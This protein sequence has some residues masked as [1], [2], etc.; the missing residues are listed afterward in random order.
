MSEDD[1]ND[2]IFKVDTV[3][4]P[5]GEEN[6][7]DAPTKVGPMAAAALRELMA[8]AEAKVPQRDDPHAAAPPS[9]PDP[10]PEPVGEAKELPKVYDEGSE[11]DEAALRSDYAKPPNVAPV[12]ERAPE[13]V[14]HKLVS[15]ASHAPL[16]PPN[17]ASGAPE[18]RTDRVLI[19]ILLALVL[20]LIYVAFVRGKLVH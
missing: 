20:G 12:A 2:D 3:P 5:P 17:L 7:Y 18:R 9:R 10:A 11:E 8:H 6:A 14:D 1:K 4:P 16:A 15:R 13:V 19:V